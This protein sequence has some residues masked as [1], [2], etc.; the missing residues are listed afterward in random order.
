MMAE[1]PHLYQNCQIRFK[2]I[3]TSISDKNYLRIS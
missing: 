3:S 1:K 2:E